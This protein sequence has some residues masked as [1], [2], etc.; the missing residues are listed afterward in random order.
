MTSLNNLSTKQSFDLVKAII[1]S[2]LKLEIDDSIYKIFIDMNSVFSIV[3]RT[4]NVDCEENIYVASDFIEDIINKALEK[5]IEI[6]FLFT[7]NNSIYHTNI[8]TD[9]CFDRSDRV[10]FNKSKFYKK[11][12]LELKKYSNEN[13]L[14]KVVNCKTFHPIA[15]IYDEASILK[16][17]ILIITRDKLFQC[18]DLRN[19]V[20]FD[21]KNYTFI[22]DKYRKLPDNIILD[23]PSKYLK[24]YFVLNG[25]KIRTGYSGLKTYGK[26]KSIQYINKYRTELDMNLEHPLKEFIDTYIGLYDINKIYENYLE[27]KNK[28]KI[29]E[30]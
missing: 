24:Y 8:Y 7:V 23:N 17:D 27:F 25:D 19:V 20:I 6:T 18:L 1:G 2:S 16:K 12:L 13:N 26:E 10:N 5:K 3:F 29:G 9:W 21:G 28:E 4:E 11:L 22:R 14:I 30:Y 15:F